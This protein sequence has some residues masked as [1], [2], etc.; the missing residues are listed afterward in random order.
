MDDDRIEITFP[1]RV[2]VRR[3]YDYNTAVVA[4]QHGMRFGDWYVIECTSVDALWDDLDSNFDV[5][6]YPTGLKLI[7][8][9]TYWEARRVA[10]AMDDSDPILPVSADDVDADLDWM[11]VIQAVVA[12]ALMDHYVFPLSNY[13]LQT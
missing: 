10:M 2:R 3:G 13:K 9:L 11:W 4:H 5:G 12:S 6:H 1:D 8:G 7:S